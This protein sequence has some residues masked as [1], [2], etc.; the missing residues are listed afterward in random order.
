MGVMIT[1]KL[2][3]ILQG[4]CGYTPFERG[5][6]L[7]YGA[8]FIHFSVIDD[9]RCAGSPDKRGRQFSVIDI[10]V[11]INSERDIEIQLAA[12]HIDTF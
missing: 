2:P 6:E 8:G 4:C 9:E 11:M 7:K 3:T 5:A 1:A 10:E 12:A